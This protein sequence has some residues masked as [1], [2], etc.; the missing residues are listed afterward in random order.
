MTVLAVE[1]VEALAVELGSA[2]EDRGRLDPL[3][4]RRNVVLRGAEVEALRG[5]EFSLDCGE[6][7]LV[8]AGGR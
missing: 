4:T 7:E 2:L 1:S 8:L 3:A 6:G 5:T